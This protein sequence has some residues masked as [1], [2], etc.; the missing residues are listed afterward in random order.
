MCRLK[1]DGKLEISWA[2]N[3]I[4]FLFYLEHAYFYIMGFPISND[5]V[6][7]QKTTKTMN[8]RAREIDLT[9][10]KEQKDNNRISLRFF[11]RTRFVEPYF[12]VLF[13]R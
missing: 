9:K 3:G 4:Y 12:C 11:W 2:D 5:K 1:V 6:P 7:K 13:F 10:I 8:E